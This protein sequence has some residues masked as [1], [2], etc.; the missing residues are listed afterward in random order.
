MTDHRYKTALKHPSLVFF[1]LKAKLQGLKSEDITREHVWLHLKKLQSRYE[2]AYEGEITKISQ[3][4]VQKNKL[5]E[6]IALMCGP[7]A[8]ILYPIIRIIKPNVVVETG[9]NLGL[10]SAVILTAL[11]HNHQESKLF[12]IDDPIIKETPY[13][14]TKEELKVMNEKRVEYL[15]K[16]GGYY[17]P[18]NLKK[19]WEMI[20]GRT[21]EKLP[22]LVSK[23]DGIDLSVHDGGA[24]Y[25]E[26][27]MEFDTIYPKLKK[28]GLLIS[29]DLHFK[30]EG[31]K[32]FG[33]VVEEYH[34]KHIFLPYW[35]ER[36]LG[37]MIK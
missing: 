15:K 22:D 31:G 8:A 1:A 30:D 16:Y 23:L 36:K 4:P 35:D 33:E 19:N 17:V 25:Y 5:L 27:K 10:T 2:K 29:S 37:I 20:W 3:F 13:S 34:L 12:S 32:A 24:K 9:V 28:G 21:E 7:W 6:D 18:Q 26:K 14:V 11:E